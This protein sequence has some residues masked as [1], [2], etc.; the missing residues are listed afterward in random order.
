METFHYKRIQL[1]KY[2]IIL[3]LQLSHFGA[4]AGDNEQRTSSTI[5]NVTVFLNQA[6]VTRLA[7]VNLQ[8]G[9]TNL[10]FDKLSNQ[11]NTNSIQVRV[12]GKINLLSVSLRDNYLKPNE[13]S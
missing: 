12:D 8:A 3:L 7:K 9:V 13:N 4:K 11:I 1:F 10:V 5:T 2:S 6:Q